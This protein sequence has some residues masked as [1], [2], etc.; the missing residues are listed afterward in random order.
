MERRSCARFIPISSTYAMQKLDFFQNK[1]KE[2]NYER[3]KI[4]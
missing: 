2:L 1:K 3:Q 4:N